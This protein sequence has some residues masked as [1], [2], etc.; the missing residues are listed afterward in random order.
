MKHSKH[1][2]DFTPRPKLRLAEVERY[3][4]KHR[5]IVPVP[6]R[7]Q[8]IALCESGKLEGVRQGENKMWLVFEDSFLRWL[9]EMDES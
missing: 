2:L 5:A 6:S 4:R 9:Q 7:R 1:V 3:I 8:L